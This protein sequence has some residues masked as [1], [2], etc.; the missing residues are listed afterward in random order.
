MRCCL[1]PLL[2]IVAITRVSI[3][4]LHARVLCIG[5]TVAIA[6]IALLF[7]SIVVVSVILAVGILLGCLR[8]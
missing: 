4:V 8:G 3:I 7:V 2:L 1:L 5:C 6:F